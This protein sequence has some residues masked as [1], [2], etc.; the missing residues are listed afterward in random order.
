MHATMLVAEAF[1]AFVLLVARPF[2]ASARAYALASRRVPPPRAAS[3]AARI[4]SV[5]VLR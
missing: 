1:V 3:R 4:G 2:V 5:R